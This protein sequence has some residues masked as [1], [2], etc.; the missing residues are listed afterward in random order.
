MATRSNGPIAAPEYQLTKRTFYL[1]DGE[2][3]VSYGIC[4]VQ[5]GEVPT[6]IYDL[7]PDEAFVRDL[8]KRLTDGEA[9]LCHFHDIAEDALAEKYMGESCP[10]PA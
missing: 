2:A 5:N 6:A 4:A 3:Y 10:C 1:P 7:D 9:A 8:V